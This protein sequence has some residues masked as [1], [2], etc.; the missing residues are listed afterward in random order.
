[1]EKIWITGAEGFMGKHLTDFLLEKGYEILA[2]FYERNLIGRMNL[3]AK[4]EECD[5]RDK[6]KV[7]SIMRKFIPDKI[8]H[9]AAQSYPVVSWE[10]PQYTLETNVIGTCNI[11]EAVKKFNPD[12]KILNACSSTEYGFVSENEI[13]IKEE[14][15]LQPLHPYGVSKLAQE[16]LALQYFTNFGIKSVSMRIFNTTGPGKINDVCSDFT[17][18]VIEIEKKINKEKKIKVGNLSTKR[19]ITDVRDVLRGFDLALKKAKMGE[20]YN[21]CGDN[22]YSMQSIVEILRNKINFY[23]ETDLDKNLVRPNDEPIIYG[24]SSKFRRETGWK[25]KIPLEKTLEDMLDYWRK[26][27]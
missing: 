25:E 7:Y 14:H 16:K 15:S 10:N 17:K 23:F 9:L 24:D 4:M 12:C 19:A 6:E 27:P 3:R 13:P 21:I 20:V 5:I 2:S 1:M 18:R 11:F 26:S 22:V 8:F